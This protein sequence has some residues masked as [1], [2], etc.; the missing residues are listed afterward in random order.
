MLPGGLKTVN[1]LLSDELSKVDE[2]IRLH[3]ASS[4]KMRIKGQGKLLTAK[5]LSR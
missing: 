1:V 2:I 5:P 3:Q 4:Y